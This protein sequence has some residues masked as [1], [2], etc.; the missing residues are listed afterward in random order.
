[1]IAS[2]GLNTMVNA[3]IYL[4]GSKLYG[5]LLNVA[6]Q[7]ENGFTEHDRLL[8]KDIALSLGDHVYLKR[9]K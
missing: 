2:M 9:L 1:M 7:E 8:L 5:C 6:V 3:P 4:N